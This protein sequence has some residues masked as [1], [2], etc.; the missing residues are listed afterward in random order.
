MDQAQIRGWLGIGL[1]LPLSCK[2]REKRSLGTPYW[3]GVAVVLSFWTNTLFPLMVTLLSEI[4]LFLWGPMSYSPGVCLWIV[5]FGL[6]WIW[7]WPLLVLGYWSPYLYHSLGHYLTG[8]LVRRIVT[9][10]LQT[11]PPSGTVTPIGNCLRVPYSIGGREYVVYLPYYPGY[12]MRDLRE[13]LEFQPDGSEER[14]PVD[15]Q[16]GVPFFATSLELGGRLYWKHPNCEDWLQLE[17]AETLDQ[18]R[19]RLLRPVASSDS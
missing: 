2:T 11:Q 12:R 6:C 5:S 10:R 9:A 8:L 14:H 4:G 7:I 19:R 18:T 13:R 3:L 15:R 17:P 1:G 16:P